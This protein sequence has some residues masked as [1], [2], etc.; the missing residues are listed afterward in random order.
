MITHTQP[1]EESLTAYS[2]NPVQGPFIHQSS[3]LSLCLSPYHS[4]HLTS[5]HPIPTPHSHQ[6]RI[7][8]SLFY[9]S[10]PSTR[11]LATYLPTFLPPYLPTSL[12]FYLPTFLSLY[13]SVSL[14]FYLSIFLSLYLSIFLS[15]YLSIFLPF[16]LPTFLPPYLFSPKIQY[17][18]TSCTSKLKSDSR[19][20][21]VRV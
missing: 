6:L 8:K 1:G 14:S 20:Y 18:M 21:F 19:D 5:P 11:Y 2:C 12:S 13:L 17:P 4:P 10:L 15:F 9:L 3:S 16:Y 7:T